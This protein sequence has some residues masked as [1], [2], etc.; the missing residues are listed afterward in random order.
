MNRSL[1]NVVL[2]GW[3]TGSTGKAALVEGTATVKQI[4]KIQDNI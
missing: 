2:G 3:G 1:A 4:R